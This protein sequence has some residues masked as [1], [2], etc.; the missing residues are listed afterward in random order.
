MRPAC[1]ADPH[2]GEAVTRSHISIGIAAM[3]AVVVASC[4]H[5]PQPP[6]PVHSRFYQDANL[7]I[8]VHS[9]EPGIGLY[10]PATYTWSGLDI[11]VADSVMTWLHVPYSQSDTHF[12]SVDTKDR[13]TALLKGT[14]DLIIASYSIDDGRIREGISFSVPYLLSYQ[15]ILVR[16]A[17]ARTIKSVADLRGKKVCTGPKSSTPYQ[18]LYAVNAERHLGI[19]IRPEIGDWVCV[20]NLVGNKVDAVVGD[21][22]ILYGYQSLHPG[23]AIVGTKVWPRPEQYGVGFIARSPEDAKEINAAIHA[24]IRDGSWARAIVASFC[25]AGYSTAA[26]CPEARLFLDNPP[27]AR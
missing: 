10:Q 9:D 8:G 5:T 1:R 25:P 11:S 15:D 2:Q 27:P 22:A 16:S 20:D 26:P 14:E 17:E 24:M 18:H 4:S 19:T 13:D 3:A 23:L 6:D 12:S 7:R 21:D